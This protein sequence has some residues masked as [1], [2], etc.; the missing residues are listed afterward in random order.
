MTE[1]EV[2][3]IVTWLYSAYRPFSEMGHNYTARLAGLGK[4]FFS[5]CQV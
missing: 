5:C 3:L 2:W 1:K 4:W